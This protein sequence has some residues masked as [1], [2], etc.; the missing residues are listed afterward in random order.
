LKI[1]RKSGAESADFDGVES[2]CGFGLNKRPYAQ[3]EKH[4][5]DL[6]KVILVY[7]TDFFVLSDLLSQA[8]EFYC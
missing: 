3:I 7:L 8:T 2:V 6:K 4:I 5:P 1:G